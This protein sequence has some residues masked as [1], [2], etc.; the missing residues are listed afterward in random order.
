VDEIAEDRKRSGVS[1][2][3]REGDGVA[4][5]EAHTKAGGAEDTHASVYTV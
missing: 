5:A 4:N 1:M 3:E 2:V